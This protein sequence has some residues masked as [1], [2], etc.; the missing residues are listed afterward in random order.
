MHRKALVG[1]LIVTVLG[2]VLRADAASMPS[3]YQSVDERA[4]AR[5]ARNLAKYGKYEDRF[6]ED[7][8]RWPPGAVAMFAL[9]HEVKPVMTTGRRWDVPSA[10]AAQA[11]VGTLLIPAVFVFA[12]LLGAGAVGGL[13]AATG[14]ALYPPLIKAS[15]DLLTEPLG[16]LML[17]GA[18]IAVALALRRP[19]AGRGAAAGVVLGLA[20]LVRADLVLL[21]FACAALLGL[22]AWRSEAGG[23][24][25]ARTA[26]AL[27]VAA[28]VVLAP[29]SAYVSSETGR[30]VPVS[31]GGASNLYVGTY[32][33]GDGTMV[34]LKRA[35]GYE[36][37]T[38]QRIV[39]DRVA[40]RRPG[41]DREAAL[42]EAA[43]TNLREHV[44]GD[45]AGF[46]AMGVRK[47]ERLWLHYTLGGYRNARPWILDL[48]RFLVLLGLA[49]VTAAL[50]VGRGRA[51]ALWIVA[52]AVA[53]VTAVNVVLVSEARHNLPFMPVVIARAAEGLACLQ[54]AR[55]TAAMRPG[56]SLLRRS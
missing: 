48:H 34:G 11:T 45:P 9:T 17:T 44:L 1:L 10:Y 7:P 20:V 53:Y 47:V 28:V 29:W 33:P 50:A 16:A 22:L 51:R 56:S 18:L 32:V 52:L 4:Y 37:T 12:L 36:A 43:K 46:A 54:R 15:G 26:V 30:F 19:T 31:S 27:V 38:P 40:A 41:L 55:F 39:I 5:L 2:G 13:L 25:A 3:R 24:A 14:V 21:P 42:R 8:V 23:A 35:L 6:M 49:S